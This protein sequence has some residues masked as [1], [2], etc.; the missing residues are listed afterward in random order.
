M[1]RNRDQDA[2]N[3]ATKASIDSQRNRSTTGVALRNGPVAHSKKRLNGLNIRCDRRL[4]VLGALS[5][6]AASAGV[7]VKATKP[8]NTTAMVTVTANWR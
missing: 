5:S 4:V 7:N 6:S 2:A 8:D 3:T 1:I